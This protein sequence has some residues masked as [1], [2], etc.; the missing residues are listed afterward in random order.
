MTSRLALALEA[1]SPSLPV[2]G[3]IAVFA[4][5]DGYDLSSLPKER[6]VIVTGFKPDYDRLNA[7]GYACETELTREVAASI[8]CVPRAKAL[9]QA[10]VAQAVEKT[11]GPILIDGAKTDGIEALYKACR[12]RADVSAALSKAHGKLFHFTASSGFD[13]WRPKDHQPIEGGFV[14]APGIFSADSV[15]PASRLLADM[16][17]AKLGAHIADLGA[18]WGY[19]SA[20]LLERSDIEILHLVE[21]EHAALTCAKTNISDSRARFHW[22]DASTWA[23][24]SP[25]DCVVM[26][27]PFHTSRTPE[28][29]IG[30]RFIRAAA[31][32]LH[33]KGQLFLVA[34]RHLPYERF[35]EQSFSEVAE[36][37][38]DTRFKLLKAARPRP[39]ARV[40]P[41]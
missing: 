36:F 33:P 15:D 1:G 31:R 22:A 39:G 14:T 9:A 23:A 38:G 32:L 10:Y 41:G 17:P 29:I 35:L 2:S 3:D 11:T 28:P 34:N 24:E 25:L 7:A 5:R 21:A 30:Q 40:S 37:G 12:K 16:L 19:L 20:R 27:P 18:G 13:D 8:I 26:N 6:C 4:P